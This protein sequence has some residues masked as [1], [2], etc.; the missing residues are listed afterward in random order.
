MYLAAPVVALLLALL[1]TGALATTASTLAIPDSVL[2][3]VTLHRR[4]GEVA[5]AIAI[6]LLVWIALKRPGARK[7]AFGLCGGIAVQGLLGALPLASPAAG[8]AHAVLAQ[9]LFAGGVMLAVV[10]SA[11]W[12]QPPQT[13]RD[14][15]W[16]SLRSLAVTLPVLVLV[17]I[18]LGAAFR[19]QW[20]G[21]MPHVV[22]AILVSMFIL[23]VGAFVMQQCKD[24]KTLAGAGRALMVVTFTQVFLGIAVYT[25]R[26]L[27]QQEAG[28]ILTMATAHVAT[29]AALLAVSAVMG[30]HIRKHV[31]PKA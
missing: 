10:T 29:G 17:Q 18:G 5:G 22:G 1:V 25:V 7:L 6:G 23:I 3:H 24:H 2:L 14:Y 31:I 16:P 9:M 28:P 19:Q 13:I 30:M 15:G 20:L 4:M 12:A 21:L 26:A 11:S 27:P 8:V